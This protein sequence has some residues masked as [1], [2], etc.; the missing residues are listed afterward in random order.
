MKSKTVSFINDITQSMIN[1][2]TKW[3]EERKSAKA[4]FSEILDY[5]R[6]LVDKVED[7]TLRQMLKYYLRELKMKSLKF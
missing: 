4:E 2:N 6:F 7:N 3:Y 1:S 5:I